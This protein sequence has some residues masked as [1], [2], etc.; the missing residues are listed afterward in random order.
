[1]DLEYDNDRIGNST[2]GSTD[3]QFKNKLPTIREEST[4]KKSQ[5]KNNSFDNGIGDRKD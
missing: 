3:G 1:M 5:R 2:L 4:Q